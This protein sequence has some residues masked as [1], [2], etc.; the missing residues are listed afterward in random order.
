MNDLTPTQPA[1]IRAQLRP[2]VST[3]GTLGHPSTSLHDR[4]LPFSRPLPAVQP[5]GTHVFFQPTV[6]ERVAAIRAVTPAHLTFGERVNREIQRVGSYF[7]ALSLWANT[8]HRAA[9]LAEGLGIDKQTYRRILKSASMNSVKAFQTL[10]DIAQERSIPASEVARIIS[11]STA[12]TPQPTARYRML[13]MKGL[14]NVTPVIVSDLLTGVTRGTYGFGDGKTAQ[15]FAGKAQVEDL[16]MSAIA[17]PRLYRT[18]GQK[19]SGYVF[20]YCVGKL[21]FDGFEE[22]HPL[23]MIDHKVV[24]NLV[25]WHESAFP[26]KPLSENPLLTSMARLLLVPTHDWGHA[27]LLYDRNA[28]TPEFKEWGDDIY[29]VEQKDGNKLL[30]NYELITASMHKFTW[31]MLFD[32]DPE[33]RPAVMNEL[34]DYHQHVTDFS[35][36]VAATQNPEV[37]LKEEN[38]LMYIPL[39]TLPFV[40]DWK[41]RELQSLFDQYPVVKEQI[42]RIL[43]NAF[44]TL[45]A[46]LDTVPSRAK[47]ETSTAEY[48]RAYPLQT[49]ANERLRQEAKDAVFRYGSHASADI[50][51]AFRAFPETLVRQF[52]SEIRDPSVF[53]TIQF[54]I[55]TLVSELIQAGASPTLVNTCI[56]RMRMAPTGHFFFHLNRNEIDYDRLE[57]CEQD[58][59]VLLV[60]VPQGSSVTLEH[61]ARTGLLDTVAKQQTIANEMVAFNVQ[62]KEVA[63]HILAA[64][65]G[66][67]AKEQLPAMIARAK[68]LSKM[69]GIE[70]AGDIYPLR[71]TVA[72]EIYGSAE[73]GFRELLGRRR[74]GVATCG[75]IMLPLHDGS[76]Q[77]TLDGVM[78]YIPKAGSSH[79]FNDDRDPDMHGIEATSFDRT[80]LAAATSVNPFRLRP[81]SVITDGC[82][83]D[84]VSEALH[85]FIST[86]REV[87]LQFDLGASNR[88]LGAG[89][90]GHQ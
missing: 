73:T 18:D 21:G 33:L 84:K 55:E 72:Q 49:E 2:R 10:L 25:Q 76:V 38:Y 47:G 39:S 43:G 79:N 54:A 35:D 88:G 50:F 60:R 83:P 7:E 58:K 17:S 3:E 63:D 13:M 65:K 41:S 37:A 12:I 51:R 69:S 45:G 42:T 82:D 5:S 62:N 46:N 71:Q 14:L 31:Q 67:P 66:L 89:L 24:A 80:Y 29:N 23:Y 64:A 74:Y 27:W 34:A 26:N 57:V 36:F 85:R 48:I 30:I 11:A 68:E 59:R 52:G 1:Q 78:V 77:S 87:N 16:S 56:E 32:S 19:D 70:G 4:F 75:P 86:L 28:Q 9:L 40:I 53:P 6:T 90:F 61:T 15:I 44:D 20:R 8:E 22:H 81:G